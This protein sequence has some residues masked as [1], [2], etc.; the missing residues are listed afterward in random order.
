LTVS[1]LLV[2]SGYDVDAVADAQMALTMVRAKSPG[3]IV[4]DANLPGTSGWEVCRAIKSDAA[5][6]HTPVVIVSA[7]VSAEARAKSVEVG[8]DEFVEKPLHND[9]F[10]ALIASLIEIR[11]TA[12]QLD[13]GENMIVDAFNREEA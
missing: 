3:L 10:L 7:D 1:A 5:T 2:R 4:V 11:D 6:H 8:A 12:K 13:V 9:V